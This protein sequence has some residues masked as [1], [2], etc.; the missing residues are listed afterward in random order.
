[1]KIRK[2]NE[3]MLVDDMN[4]FPVSRK[5]NLNDHDFKKIH[6][7]GRKV[8]Y[9]NNDSEFIECKNPTSLRKVRDYNRECNFI[10][11]VTEETIKNGSLIGLAKSIK[12][13]SDLHKLE[14]E[15]RYKI[16]IGAVDKVEKGE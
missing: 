2:F 8:Y 11:F 16:L 10:V 9:L 5:D 13:L 15:S 12:E 14:I 3:S 6:T 4:Y 1:M 7:S